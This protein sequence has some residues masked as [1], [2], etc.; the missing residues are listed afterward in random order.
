M[1]LSVAGLN[2]EGETVIGNS[3]CV[4]KSYPRFFEDVMKLGGNVNKIN[5][6]LSKRN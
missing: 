1:A 6:I 3:S 5:E 4:R 2:A